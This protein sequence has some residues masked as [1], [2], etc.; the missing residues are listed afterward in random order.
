MLNVFL[1]LSIFVFILS[2]SFQLTIDF[3]SLFIHDTALYASD[4][5]TGLSNS[6][7]LKNYNELMSYLKGHT[8]TLKLSNFTFSNDGKTHFKEV[9]SLFRL[10]LVLLIS[11][12]IML[13]PCYI[14]S[15]KTNNIASIL[16]SSMSVIIFTL[17]LSI[18]LLFFFNTAFVLFHKLFFNN[19][20]WLLDPKTDPIINIFPE[21][22]FLHCGVFI[23]LSCLILS[24]A[25]LVSYKYI[26]KHII[27][28]N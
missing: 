17:L 23:I 1:F 14:I 4:E 24:C 20:L 15:I 12:F 10:N 18:F 3:K 19:S 21:P 27:K 22:F 9:K 5:A 25:F 7:I 6:I 13:I 8:P 2:L 16:Y 28:T 26:K 11:S